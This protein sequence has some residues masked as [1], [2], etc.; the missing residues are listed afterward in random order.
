[1]S[2]RRLFELSRGSDGCL[3]RPRMND[4]DVETTSPRL[5]TITR[6]QQSTDELQVRH[7]YQVFPCLFKLLTGASVA[8]RAFSEQQHLRWLL[9]VTGELGTI[10]V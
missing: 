4:H 7:A 1:M 3:A 8:W 2:V 6:L 5:L 9:D 10:H